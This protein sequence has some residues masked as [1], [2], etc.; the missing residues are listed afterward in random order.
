MPAADVRF[1]GNWDVLGLESTASWDYSVDGVW[2]PSGATFD[3][4]APVRLARRRGLR[5]G[6]DGPHIG[7]PRRVRVGSR[8]PRARRAHRDREVEAADGRF[9][10]RCVTAS[11][12]SSSWPI[13]KPEPGPRHR[14]CTSD[15][16]S[17]SAP[18]SRPAPRTRPRSCWRAKRPCTPRRTEPTSSGGPTSSPARDA[19]ARRPVANVLPRH[20]RRVA[21]LLRRRPRQH[22]ARTILARRLRAGPLHAIQ[23]R[24]DVLRPHISRAARARRRRRRIRLVHRPR[25][26]ALPGGVRHAV[27]LHRRRRS[28]VPRRQADHRAVH[29]H[30]V[31]RGPDHAPA[32]HDLRAQ[33]GDPTAGARRQASREHRGAH[34]EPV[35]LR[36]RDQSVAGRLRRY[37]SAVGEARRPHGRDHRH[38]P[39]AHGRRMVRIRR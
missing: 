31:S 35:A 5:A 23:L 21:A 15:S 7:R 4:F 16:R 37:G 19:L 36:G 26:R 33:A 18:R 10:R 8:A 27:S 2:V 28:S 9:G 38:R 20:P 13:S 11:A 32:V 22:R 34:R 12:S 25:Q 29:P 3:F 14:G 1:T 17:R 39:R 6:S 24:G 30:P